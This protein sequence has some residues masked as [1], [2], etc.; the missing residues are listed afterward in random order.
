MDKWQTRRI[1]IL[2]TTYPQHS[3]KYKETVCTGGIFEDTFEMCR[4]H[5][6]PHRYLEPGH[7][8]HAFQL[9]SAKVTKHDTDP[10][11]ES[12]RIDSQSIIPE[13]TIPP[14]DHEVRRSYLERSS[15]MCRSVEDLLDRY[16]QHRISLRI[17]IPDGITDC[18]VELRS[19]AERRD[20]DKQELARASQEVFS[21]GEK[22]KPLDFPEAKFFVH[23]VC[24]DSRCEGHKMSLHQW[25]I[26]ELY[27]KY[28]DRNEAKEK[29]LQEM[30]RRLDQGERDV[31]LFSEVSE[32]PC[33]ILV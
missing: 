33:S 20:W 24:A 1:L 27:R 17:I 21:F 29:V 26:H 13:E 22:P 16:K 32:I 25:G 19:E 9:I 8:F 18:T 5:P 23:W 3:K 6:V 4:L 10:R 2:G 15:H 7:Q 12:F 11:P 31:F 28:S 14:A 30:R